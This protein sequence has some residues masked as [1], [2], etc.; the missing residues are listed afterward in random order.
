LRRAM[1]PDFD[2]MKAAKIPTGSISVSDHPAPTPRGLA[3]RDYRRL[4]A[5]L[6]SYSSTLEIYGGGGAWGQ[7]ETLGGKLSNR[8]V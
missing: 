5:R 1:R 2:L 8:L 6:V 3:H 7:N 4:S